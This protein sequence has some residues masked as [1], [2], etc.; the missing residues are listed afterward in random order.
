MGYWDCFCLWWV[1]KYFL[2]WTSCNF[3]SSGCSKTHMKGF[4]S[5]YNTAVTREER[6]YFPH[7][8]R[9]EFKICILTKSWKIR[10]HHILKNLVSHY[11]NR[12]LCSKTAGSLVVPRV[13][14]SKTRASLR[15]SGPLLCNQ[16]P[17]W[18]W[19]TGTH[20]IF[21]IRFETFI[22]YKTCSYDWIGWPWAL[23]EDFLRCTEHFLSLFT[24]M[25]LY[26]TTACHY[27]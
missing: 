14:K 9:I 19:K 4:K 7:V 18:I 15:L 6:S 3:L 10:S 12:I 24:P 25:H 27:I 23:L 20:S 17:V 8:G 26:V 11:P 1:Q 13:S 21:K 22:F 16:L 5:T 2:G